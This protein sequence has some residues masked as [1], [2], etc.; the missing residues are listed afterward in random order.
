[1]SDTLGCGD[2]WC[3]FDES[4]VLKLKEYSITHNFLIFEDRKFADIGNTVRKQYR[5]GIYKIKDWAHFITVHAIPG[6]GIMQGLFED[7]INRSS[8]L[9]AKMSSAENLMNDT[10]TRKVFNI[11][12]KYAEHVSG[13]ICHANT[14]EELRKL[15]NKIPN[16]Q[17]M[18]MPGVKLEKGT[19]ATGQQY[20]TVEDAILGG[21]DCIVVG[22]GIIESDNPGKTA[23]EFKERAW[24]L[25]LMKQITQ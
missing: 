24:K 5:S 14:K 23:K 15:R 2:G 8:F 19:D 6:E 17:L 25:N 18:L 16:G 7:I 10:Y 1:M 21:A 12:E 11:G 4:F 13:Y 22:R 9:L 20:T 3:D